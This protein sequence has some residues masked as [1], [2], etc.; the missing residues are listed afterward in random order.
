MQAKYLNCCG[1]VAVEV[2]ALTKTL[3]KC[4]GGTHH[5]I[6]QTCY[7][8]GHKMFEIPISLQIPVLF[9]FAL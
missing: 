5:N 8:V 2:E 3:N 7:A 9:N 1:F 4:P 6:K